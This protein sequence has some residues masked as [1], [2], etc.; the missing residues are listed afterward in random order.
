MYTHFYLYISKCNH[1][2]SDVTHRGINISNIITLNV[3]SY[4]TLSF[5]YCFFGDCS[6]IYFSVQSISLLSRSSSK[7]VLWFYF[8]TVGLRFLLISSGK[9]R[10]LQIALAEKINGS[11]DWHFIKTQTQCFRRRLKK[12]TFHKAPV[13]LFNIIPQGKFFPN[14]SWLSFYAL[15]HNN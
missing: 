3:L 14:S 2:L 15:K 12:I 11:L 13:Q 8:F 1:L 5:F 9:V 4:I 6:I 7:S 10:L